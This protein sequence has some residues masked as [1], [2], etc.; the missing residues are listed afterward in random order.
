MAVIF[1]AALHCFL[2]G[3]NAFIAS[4]LCLQGKQGFKSK[5]GAIK[6]CKE[7]K[8]TAP[9]NEWSNIP[10]CSSIAVSCL[11]TF[12]SY[13]R[14]DISIFLFYLRVYFFI[15]E[16]HCMDKMAQLAVRSLH[17]LEI[18]EVCVPELLPFQY[19][20]RKFGTQKARPG[21]QTST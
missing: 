9:S 10:F 7:N 3:Y 20:K 13:S 12:H 8:I 11:H 17:M 16:E 18:I 6:C 19:P 4:L 1:F 21:M 14:P 5:A 2:L 15:S